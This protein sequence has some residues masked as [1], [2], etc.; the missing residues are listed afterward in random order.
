MTNMG[1]IVM[2]PKGEWDSTTKYEF[3]DVITYQGSTWLAKTSNQ[4]VPPA[5]GDTWQLMVAAPD[6]TDIENAEQAREDAE[7]ARQEAEKTRQDADNERNN[8]I[9]GLRFKIESNGHIYAD[10]PK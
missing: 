5:E 9:Y 2:L 6:L 8:Y 3:L 7:A 10:F 1:R 4:N